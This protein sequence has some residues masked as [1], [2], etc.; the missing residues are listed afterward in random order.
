MNQ[1]FTMDVSVERRPHLFVF[2][3]CTQSSNRKKKYIYIYNLFRSYFETLSNFLPGN[4]VL[5][6]VIRY[7]V[8]KFCICHYCYSIICIQKI[9]AQFEN[10]TTTKTKIGCPRL[11]LFISLLTPGSLIT[12]SNGA[13]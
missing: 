2:H 6:Y 7:T 9:Q 3:T 11:V 12:Q 1:I 10:K 4:R 5:P 8:H 13:A